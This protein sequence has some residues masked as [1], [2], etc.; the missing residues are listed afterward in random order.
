MSELWVTPFWAK[1][2]TKEPVDEPDK[3]K[4]NRRE[5]RRRKRVL[6]DRFPYVQLVNRCKIISVYDE[7]GNYEATFMGYKQCAKAIGVKSS[8]A[9]QQALKGKLRLLAGK[10][11]RETKIDWIDGLPMVSKKNIAAVREKKK[12]V[13]R[14]A[15]SVYDLDG[16]YLNTFE[17]VTE[18]SRATGVPSGRISKMI[19][20]CKDEGLRQSHGF[21]FRIAKPDPSF[22]GQRWIRRQITPYYGRYRM[23]YISKDYNVLR[24]KTL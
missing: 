2:S 14:T 20:N 10:Q 23:K 15:V 5:M 1:V 17:S 7:K 9:I 13:P 19:H 8:T 12:P 11:L 24:D 18:A 21:I 22:D 4:N 3:A 16:F 6:E